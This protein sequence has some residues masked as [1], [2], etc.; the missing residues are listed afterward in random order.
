MEPSVTPLMSCWMKYSTAAL[1]ASPS[2][3]SS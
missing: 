3:R 2:R 1:F